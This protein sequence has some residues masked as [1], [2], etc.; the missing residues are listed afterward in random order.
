MKRD[1]FFVAGIWIVLTV[2]GVY[3][4][5][6]WSML[7]EGYTREAEV[8]NEA[9][10]LLLV[11]A[12]PVFT[13]TV[14]MLGYSAIRFRSQGRPDE[15]GPNLVATPRVVGAWLVI[16]SGLALTV[17][18]NPGFVGLADLRGSSSADMVVEVASQRW[19]WE[20]RYENGATTGLEP[21]DEMVVPVDSRIRFDITATD[22]VHSFWVPAFGVKIDAV[23]GRTTEL[24]VTTERTGD[25]ESDPKLRVQCAELCGLGHAEMSLPVRVVEP[26]E[27]EAWLDELGR[28]QLAAEEGA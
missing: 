25:Y 16:T 14:T 20:V 15:D 28:E 8:V 11:L 9:Y 7:P 22:V 21:G 24:F 18:I 19:S 2:I 5:V 3:A 26:A 13:F 4:A 6:T 23:P 17:L 27:F 1:W 10:L 12:V